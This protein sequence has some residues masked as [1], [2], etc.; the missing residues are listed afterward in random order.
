MKRNP[1]LITPADAGYVKADTL[2]KEESR[3]DFMDGLPDTQTSNLYPN[4]AGEAYTFC[5]EVI[6]IT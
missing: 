2:R 6:L 3:T 1:A 5:M 4:F